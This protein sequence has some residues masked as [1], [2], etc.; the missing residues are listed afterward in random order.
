MRNIK[1]EIEYDG[2]N[3][4]GWQIQQKRPDQIGTERTIQGVIERVLSGILQEEI[5]I[6]GAGRTDSGVHALGQVANFKT[7]SKM[8][9]AVMQRAL[10]ALLPKDIVI[11]D[12][13]EAKPDFNSRYNAKSKTYRYQILNRDYST[14]FDRLYQYHIPYKLDYRLMAREGRN[15]IGRRDFK[16]F[17]ATEKK[18]KMSIRNV[19]RLSVRKDGPV[20]NIDIEANGFL[21]NMVRNIVGTLIEIGRGKMPAGSSRRILRAKDRT[22]AGPTAPA[23]GLSLMRVRY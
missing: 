17:Q 21:Y 1:L 23:K 20:I 10:N 5:R 9:M 15:L 22:Q 16:S 3:Y 12:I 2:T 6:I 14:A 8:P 7:K 4:R 11:A 18:E 13:E 19:R